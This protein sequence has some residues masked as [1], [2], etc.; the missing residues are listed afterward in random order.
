METAGIAP[1]CSDRSAALDNCIKAIVR[2]LDL[3]PRDAQVRTSWPA[4]CTEMHHKRTLLM[5]AAFRFPM[6]NKRPISL[7]GN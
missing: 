5:D 6:T 1:R 3:R 2:T 7:S 4:D